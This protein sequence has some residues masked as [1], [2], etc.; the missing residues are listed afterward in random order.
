MDISFRRHTSAAISTVRC[1]GAS[2]RIYTARI[3][4]CET[5]IEMPV[6]EAIANGAIL[7]N[8]PK[9]QPDFSSSLLILANEIA[10]KCTR[11]IGTS[12]VQ[13]TDTF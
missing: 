6:Q 13:C 10:M 12:W 1:V 3:A 7:G 8:L 5:P 11:L 4:V 2:H 9:S